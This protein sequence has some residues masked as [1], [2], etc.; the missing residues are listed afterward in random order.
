MNLSYE[1]LS[2]DGIFLMENGYDMFMWIGRAVNPAIIGTLTGFQSL[3]GVDMS[4]LMI[5][6]ENSDFSTRVQSVVSYYQPAQ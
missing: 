4:R 6:P 1:R 5:I 3:D 2:S